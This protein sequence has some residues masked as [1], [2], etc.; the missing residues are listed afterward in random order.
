MDHPDFHWSHNVVAKAFPALVRQYWK[1]IGLATKPNLD[2][3]RDLCR[4]IDLLH[5]QV[6]ANKSRPDNVEYPWCGM[7][8]G[9]PRVLAPVTEQFQLAQRMMTPAGRQL[10]KAAVLLTRSSPVQLMEPTL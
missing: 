9:Q 5:P 6:D 1:A 2:Q 10:M 7:R 8:E 3:M 4:E